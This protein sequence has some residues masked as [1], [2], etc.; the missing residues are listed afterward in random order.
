MA[1]IRAL[2]RVRLPAAG[3]RIHIKRDECEGGR[4]GERGWVIFGRTTLSGST[5]CSRAAFDACFGRLG[6]GFTQFGIRVS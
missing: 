5:Q 3:R 4:G 6:S 2:P 1:A